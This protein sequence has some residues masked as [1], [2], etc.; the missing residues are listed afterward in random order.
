MMCSS[1]IEKLVLLSREERRKTRD[2]KCLEPTSK[3]P[4]KFDL[5]LETQKHR[6]SDKIAK[7]VLGVEIWTLRRQVNP[8]SLSEQE[9]IQ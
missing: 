6:S 7:L 8:C 3:T 5:V 9:K 1:K 2:R 4:Q